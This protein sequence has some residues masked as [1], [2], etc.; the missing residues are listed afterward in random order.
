MRAAL[1]FLDGLE[2]RGSTDVYSAVEPAIA[3]PPRSGVPGLVLVMSDG[4][5]TSGNLAGRNLINALTAENT[6][7]NTIYTFGG[8]NTVNRYLLDL[9]AYR[10][11]GMTHIAPK[12]EDIDEHLPGFFGQVSDPILVDLRADYGRIDAETVFP[13]VLPDFYSGRVVTVYGKFDPARDEELVLR[14][15][16]RAEAVKKEI[17]LKASLRDA[18]VG[19]R[20]VAQ[21]WAFEKSYDLI[22]EITRVG[23]T[24]D[25]M[26]EL[27]RLGQVYDVRTAYSQ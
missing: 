6:H 17:V 22:G 12:I 26:D 1:A 24:P 25:L 7:G 5:P 10:N 14:L 13:R 15:E 4:R 20:S 23:E 18:S 27:R 2:S 3:V 19:G 8:G 21:S 9:L 11:K 16:G